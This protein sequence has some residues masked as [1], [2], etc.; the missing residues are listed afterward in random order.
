MRKLLLIFT[1]V[2]FISS[3]AELDEAAKD[4][5][6]GCLPAQSNW[7]CYPASNNDTKR[8][9]GF[10]EVVSEQYICKIFDIKGTEAG[11]YEGQVKAKV[12]SNG[13]PI[14]YGGLMVVRERTVHKYFVTHGNGYFEK[15]NADNFVL[16]D[17]SS[18]LVAEIM[19]QDENSKLV[20]KPDEN[21]YIEGYFENDSLIRGKFTKHT[22][23]SSIIFE[24]SFKKECCW[25]LQPVFHTGTYTLE[26][27]TEGKL[28]KYL[29]EGVTYANLE[30]YKNEKTA[31]WERAFAERKRIAERREIAAENIRKQVALATE[32][33]K[34]EL[35]A[36]LFER[37]TG[38]GFTGENN[39]ATCVQN[40]AFN[41]RRLAQQRYEFQTQL[42]QQAKIVQ[43]TQEALEAQLAMN[44]ASEEVTFLQIF[45]EA[46]ADYDW[47]T[48]IQLANQQKQINALAR[49]PR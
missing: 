45:L 47:A 13:E 14:P 6:G 18:A 7:S 1:A 32:K 31:E 37:C 39:I 29:H 34:Q 8:G 22:D 48:H 49:R 17:Y 11:I 15:L 30:D 40:E 4:C 26:S 27:L 20:G 42:A 2:I 25:N 16:D 35:L 33:R 38:Y 3:C 9:T 43:E 19:N 41:D 12:L 5:F 10:V 36:Q 24:G 21:Y 28:T 23:E 46:I 44:K